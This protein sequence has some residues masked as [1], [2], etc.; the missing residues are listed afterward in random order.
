MVFG[1]RRGK[2]GPVARLSVNI[3]REISFRLTRLIVLHW[4]CVRFRTGTILLCA[5]V[6]LCSIPSEWGLLLRG[7]WTS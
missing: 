7:P 6:E 5:P 4:S 3:K 2:R 1:V